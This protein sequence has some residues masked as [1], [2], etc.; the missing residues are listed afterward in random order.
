MRLPYLLFFEFMSPQPS[1]VVGNWEREFETWGYFEVGIYNGPRDT[2][3][4]VLKDFK[5]GRLDVGGCPLF[6]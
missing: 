1:T 4:D 2:R 5:M 3:K 6:F